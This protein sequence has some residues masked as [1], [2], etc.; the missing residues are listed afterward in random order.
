MDRKNIPELMQLDQDALLARLYTDVTGGKFRPVEFFSDGTGN[1]YE[2]THRL[3]AVLWLGDNLHSLYEH[4]CVSWKYCAKRADPGLSDHV[5]LASAV[6]DVLASAALGVPPFTISVL[7]VKLGLD[8]FCNCQEGKPSRRLIDDLVVEYASIAAGT[9]D[10]SVDYDRNFHSAWIRF[11]KYYL[12]RGRT[13]DAMKKIDELLEMGALVASDKS[14][15]WNNAAWEIVELGFP[16]KA[17][18]P[19]ERATQV[20]P[21]SCACWDTL[22]WALL[23]AERAAEAVAALEEA[24]RRESGEEKSNMLAVRSRL[25][26]A[27]LRVGATDR[28]R[29]VLDEMEGLDANA[30]GIRDIRVAVTKEEVHALDCAVARMTLPRNGTRLAKRLALLKAYLALE[31]FPRSAA[32]ETVREM[33]D[34]DPDSPT[35]REAELLLQEACA[36]D[37]DRK[38][39]DS[40]LALA[41]RDITARELEAAG[42]TVDLTWKHTPDRG[43]VFTA[44]ASKDKGGRTSYSHAGTASEAVMKLRDRLLR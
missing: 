22:G 23:R 24:V 41:R 28:A 39:N 26:S 11:A 38:A 2:L 13:D 12:K 17:V 35:A 4:I 36:R 31:E 25:A 8:R 7:L 37:D 6:A 16:A 21:E 18:G 44:S 30:R 19:A 3:V 15:F 14:W 20:A 1:A 9:A 43:Y 29:I 27:H 40:A 33:K 32:T 34:I 42:Y 5:A 10:E